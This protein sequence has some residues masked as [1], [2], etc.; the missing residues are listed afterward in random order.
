MT[1]EYTFVILLTDA[2]DSKSDKTCMILEQNG[3]S[4]YFFKFPYC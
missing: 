3:T 4:P 2:A 1:N